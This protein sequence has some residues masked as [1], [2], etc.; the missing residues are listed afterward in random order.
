MTTSESGQ[1]VG[2]RRG[3][4]VQVTVVYIPIFAA[5]AAAAA[6]RRADVSK[7]CPHAHTRTL[8]KYGVHM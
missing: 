3:I 1:N 7:P 8:P 4:A 6:H 5:A 2:Y